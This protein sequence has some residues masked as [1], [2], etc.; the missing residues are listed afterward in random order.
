M[1]RSIF[2]LF[3]FPF[4]FSCEK[5]VTQNE[6]VYSFS[7]SPKVDYTYEEFKR[8]PVCEKLTFDTWEVVFDSIKW[9]IC[10]NDCNNVLKKQGIV[11]WI[12]ARKT[13]EVKRDGRVIRDMSIF[14]WKDTNFDCSSGK[15]LVYPFH[16]GYGNLIE[17]GY[18]EGELVNDTTLTLYGITPWQQSV[19]NGDPDDILRNEAYYTLVLRSDH[20]IK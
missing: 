19:K 13:L 9:M 2:L 16:D 17:D 12:P 1:K 6:A 20:L 14:E 10:Y 15:F 18:L 11:K 7:S 5:D 8:L 4:I 3:V